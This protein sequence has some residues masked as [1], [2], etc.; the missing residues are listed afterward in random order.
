MSPAR[1]IAMLCAV[2][3]AWP[4]PARADTAPL[5]STASMAQP[6]E[7]DAWGLARTHGWV[8]WPTPAEGGCR[9][10]HVPPRGEGPTG[11]TRWS[12]PLSQ[13]P[14]K[15]AAAGERLYLV[16]SPRENAPPMNATRPVFSIS[17]VPQ[18]ASWSD[19]PQDRLD[20]APALDVPGELAGLVGTPSGRLAALLISARPASVPPRIAVL[21]E[22]RWTPIALPDPEA[23]L[24][25]TD[26][27]IAGY[28]LV[29]SRKGL[30]LVVLRGGSEAQVAWWEL[31]L[32][33]AVKVAARPA[34]ECRRY[35]VDPAWINP[36][37]QFFESG[38]VRAAAMAS[39]R[40]DVEVVTLRDDAPARRVMMLE[41]AAA[42]S[43][44]LVPMDGVG[45]AVVLWEGSAAASAA[46]P[47]MPQLCEFSLWTGR[48]LA[49][50]PALWGSAAMGNRMLWLVLVLMALVSTFAFAMVRLESP[51]DE[52][53]LPDS[54]ALAELGRRATAG[55]IDAAIVLIVAMRATGTAW[56]E[57]L[58]IQSAGVF[59]TWL[60]ALALGL[61]LGTLG[62]W[63][64]GRTIGKALAGCRVC[65]LGERAS[66]KPTLLGALA[67][68][69]VK[70]ILPPSLLTALLDPNGRHRGDH[71]ART[72][73]VVP[74]EEET[75]KT[76]E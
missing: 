42:A 6:E 30:A 22:Q 43:W 25:A 31:T 76:P 62:E 14:E 19:R 16:F 36:N 9:L 59:F 27:S 13:P 17:A 63:L 12:I 61:T 64:Y 21:G 47:P 3:L 55:V 58:A 75:L 74:I 60:L 29:P 11:V 28:R 73:V 20:V 44:A 54:Y 10:I 56:A 4:G 72:A 39:P 18:G 5:P 69:C 40:G 34:W 45:R 37:T 50:G 71:L 7:Q 24:L 49:R 48:V 38:S 52:V 2:V 23:D 15:I 8:V 66:M 68:N 35:R 26:R 53:S 46:S 67:R 57:M 41:N 65:R 51:P 70:W 32:G 33:D 1:R